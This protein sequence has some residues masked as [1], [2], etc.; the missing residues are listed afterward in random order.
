ML[1]ELSVIAPMGWLSHSVSETSEAH[2]TLAISIGLS[3]CSAKTQGSLSRE[4]IFS[5]L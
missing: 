2:R 3:Q 5:V 4:S 1:A